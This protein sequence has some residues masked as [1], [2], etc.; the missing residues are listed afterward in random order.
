MLFFRDQY[1]AVLGYKGNH[2]RAAKYDPK[3]SAAFAAFIEGDCENQHYHY[4]IALHKPAAFS[5]E[6]FVMMVNLLW[7]EVT[8]RKGTRTDCKVIYSDGWAEY[9]TKQL[10]VNNT[11]AYDELNNNIY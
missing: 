8:H 9:I 10:Q 6:R 11:M 7:H 2:K 3:L 5:D 1:N 4:H